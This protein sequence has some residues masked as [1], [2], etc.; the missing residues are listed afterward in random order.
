MDYFLHL[1]VYIS[2][3][4]MLA[5][6]LNLVVG[7]T[8]LLSVSHAAFYGIGAYG[9]GILT[10]DHQLNF[11][12]A[13]GIAVIITM[14]IA[15]LIGFV[16]SRFRGD[17]YA[18]CSLG[19]NV[20]IFAILLNAENITHG[21]LGI[22]GLPRPVILGIRLGSTLSFLFFSMTIALCTFFLCRYVVRSSCGRV[23]KAI[24]EDED[25]LAVFGYRPSRYKYM[26]FIFSAG[27]AGLAGTLFASYI[28]FIDPTLFTI[29]E[30]VYILSLIILGGL[31]S[32]WG[33]V[34]GTLLL[35]L[36]PEL[37]RFV[38]FPTESAAQ[39][40]Q[41]IYGLLLV[42]LMMYRPRGILGEYKL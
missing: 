20:I 31:G 2:I 1:A 35:Q 3:S 33:S 37:L 5:L 12:L 16:L 4:V 32:L 27:I 40:R 7:Y 19:F 42:I 34:I 15:G 14:G 10:R 9:F 30:S 8:G 25:A 39:L 6:S 23:L 36:L 13:Q 17:Y 29:H 28:T 22:A 38:G 26:I 21:T 41:L 24:R 18:L 11:F